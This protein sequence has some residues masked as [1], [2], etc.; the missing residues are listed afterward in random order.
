[1]KIRK[2]IGCVFYL[3][4]MT[5][6]T[7]IMYISYYCLPKEIWIVSERLDQ[8]Q[9]NGIAF[10]EYLNTNHPEISSYYLLNRKCKRIDK[11]N[12]IGKVLIKGTLKHKLYFLKSNVLAFTEKNMIEPWGSNVFYKYFARF[13]PKKIKVFLQHGITDKD[14]SSIYGKQVSNIDVFVTS[15]T[16]EE[17][18]IIEK[19]GYPLQEVSN[20]GMSRY[21]KLVENYKLKE[22]LIVYMPTWRRNLI[23]LSNE[24]K[25]Y[26][27]KAREAFVH[28]R[29][30]NEIQSLLVSEAFWNLLEK[31]DFKFITITHH[32]I[33]KFSDE[34]KVYN[35][36]MKIYKSEEI[37][38]RDLLQKAKIFVTDYSSTHFDSAYIGNTN[39]Y[40]QFDKEEFRKV[41]AG[42]SYFDYEKH[43]FGNISY[44]LPEFLTQ[45]KIAMENDGRRDRIY[46]KR[47]EEFFEFRDS[48]NS[49]R[50][51]NFLKKVRT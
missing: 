10:F 12:K 47:V 37:E 45:I 21:D 27:D 46:T 1:M 33:N 11:V 23:D 13:Y 25:Q 40:Y 38:I 6:C 26:I 20:T 14:V 15:S 48:Q 50:L 44:N 34:F 35:S 43:G 49:E 19:F 42:K 17:K 51:Y 3:I 39:I 32:A 16:L 29:Y 22:K 41:H 5:L 24:N 18:F 31:Y 30:Y 36:R 7:L 9:D 8:A 2:M 4:D 28:S